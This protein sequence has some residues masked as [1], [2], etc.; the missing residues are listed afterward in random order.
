MAIQIDSTEIIP[1]LDAE[2]RMLAAEVVQHAQ[3]QIL[4]YGYL[5]ESLNEKIVDN[6]L[7]TAECENRLRDA[8]ERLQEAE[9]VAGYAEDG[10][11]YVPQYFY[12]DVA[13]QEGLLTE[14]ENRGYVLQAKANELGCKIE[15]IAM[16]YNSCAEKFRS[17]T[18][19]AC[20]RL[21]EIECVLDTLRNQQILDGNGIQGDTRNV[22]SW[23]DSSIGGWGES[24]GGFSG[25]LKMGAE[26]PAG[27]ELHGTGMSGHPQSFMRTREVW[28]TNSDGSR[29]YDSPFET[30]NRLDADQ[31]KKSGFAGTCG[32]CACENIIRMSGAQIDEPAIVEFAARNGLCSR[33]MTPELNGG[34]TASDRQAILKS[35]GISS[36][37]CVQSTAAVAK[38]VEEGRGVIVVVDSGAF[39]YDKPNNGIHAVVVTSV[40]R[41]KNGQLIGFYICDSGTHGIDGARYI[42]ADKLE[43]SFVPDRMNVTKAIIR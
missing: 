43:K 5:E 31:G 24:S 34:T 20:A 33:N 41:D 7:K 10:S 22:D 32:L 17:D 42:L 3:D 2:L 40:K 14:L 4:S 8:R 15:N 18:E 36:T 12:D 19:A 29:T 13:E 1:Q 26:N 23:R 30:G 6:S 11:G 35:Y 39:W 21:S 37:L 16:Q 28:S 38:Y 25:F 9:N 27:K